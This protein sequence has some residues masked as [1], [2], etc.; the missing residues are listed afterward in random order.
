[1]CDAEPA[2][3][4]VTDLLSSFSAEVLPSTTPIIQYQVGCLFRQW[5]KTFGVLPLHAL[6]PSVCHRW[7]EG[8]LRRGLAPR[9]VKERMA[10]LQRVLG[11]A[12]RQGW[13]DSNPLC[14]VEK[15]NPPSTPPRLL[16]P[17][18]HQRLLAACRASTHPHLYAMV[19]LS[20]DTGLQKAQ[21][22]QLRWDEVT[23]DGPRSVVC[24]THGRQQRPLPLGAEVVDVL[25]QKYVARDPAVPWV[26]ARRDGRAPITFQRAWHNTRL[27]AGLPGYRF[28]ALRHTAPSRLVRLVLWGMLLWLW[29]DDVLAW[30]IEASAGVL[31]VMAT[32][33]GL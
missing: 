4:T 1:L 8:L 2:P 29:G 13:L 22:Q 17:Q 32:F 33:S 11:W 21:V 12:T 7:R 9:T 28:D 30:G 26:F 25:Q 20:L 6:T 19:L 27:K 5:K 24:L 31:G 18:E 3:R 15:P 14:R 23:L 10:Q 16:T